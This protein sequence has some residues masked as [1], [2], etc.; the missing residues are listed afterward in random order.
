M[1]TLQNVPFEKLSVQKVLQLIGEEKLWV[2]SLYYSEDILLY[3]LEGNLENETRLIESQLSQASILFPE[4]E[5]KF[6]QILF[7]VL[8]LQKIFSLIENREIE[9]LRIT[10]HDL[11]KLSKYDLE[12]KINKRKIDVE[13]LL[14]K[15]SVS[16]TPTP[17][18]IPE[19]VQKIRFARN[20]PIPYKINTKK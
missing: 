15:V 11:V 1:I 17:T 9:I 10:V 7:D 8:P 13:D 6:F 20:S 12:V 19:K 4:F 5:Y 18:P 14:E 2:I 16:I 3:A